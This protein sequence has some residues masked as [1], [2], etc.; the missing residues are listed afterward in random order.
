MFV[1]VKSKDTLK[2]LLSLCDYDPETKLFRSKIGKDYIDSIKIFLNSK[3]QNDI[4]FTIEDIMLQ[5]TLNDFKFEGVKDFK[6]VCNLE[7][8]PMYINSEYRKEN[9]RILVSNLSDECKNLF[10]NVYGL[11]YIMTCNLNNKDEHII[12]IGQ[13]RNTFFDRL[14]SYNCGVITN[15]HTASTTNIKI[16]QS[17]V[18]TRAEFNLYICDCSDENKFFTWYNRT[19]PEIASN[20]SVAYENIIVNEFMKEF[21]QKPLANVQTKVTNSED[22]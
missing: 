3:N 11:V 1:K 13:T 19:S 4:P 7:A 14:G 20:K 8:K 6:F 16:L 2:K 22:D 15:C 10:S 21:G 9:E 18:A 17:F 12:K 5:P